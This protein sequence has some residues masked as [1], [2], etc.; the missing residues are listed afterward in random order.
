MGP[1]SATKNPISEE[2][3]YEPGAEDCQCRLTGR[4]V[5]VLCKM[6]I[7]FSGYDPEEYDATVIFTTSAYPCLH[8]RIQQRADLKLAEAFNKNLTTGC[9]P[10]WHQ[11]E[12]PSHVY[13]FWGFFAVFSFQVLCVSEEEKTNTT[14]ERTKITE[15]DGV[16]VQRIGVQA[17]EF[18]S[19]GR[20]HDT[21]NFGTTLTNTR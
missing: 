13:M 20:I 16:P 21:A 11:N 7:L 12:L 5:V 19:P 14:P 15:S 2:N 18:D 1:L 4:Y 10:D 9:V 17:A 3:D 6:W 8:D